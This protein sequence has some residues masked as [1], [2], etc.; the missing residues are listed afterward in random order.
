VRRKRTARAA[1]GGDQNA[2]L[3]LITVTGQVV[4]VAPPAI[5]ESL[6][7]MLARLRLADGTDVPAR[8]GLTSTV[9]GEGVTYVTRSLALV[10]A[11]DTGRR[12]C[13]VDLNW[14]DPGPWPADESGGVAGVL[15]GEVSLDDAVLVTGTPGVFVLPCGGADQA[16]R[17]SLAQSDELDSMLAVLSETFDHVLLDLPAVTA[18]S[19]ALS[20]VD[21]SRSVTFVVGQGA[22][23]HAQVSASLEHLTGVSVLGVILNRSASRV[24]EKLRH[25]LA[26][27]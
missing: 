20:L 11:N 21:R 10:L 8:V 1:A 18:T 5:C 3:A 14:A 12:V 16:Q 13:V 7:Y 26:V 4:H 22:A 27:V 2:S 24:P 23:S 25:R 6:R 9:A 19:E 17:P 15:R